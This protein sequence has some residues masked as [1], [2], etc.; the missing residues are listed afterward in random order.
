MVR[1][2]AAGAVRAAV[3]GSACLALRHQ[4]DKSAVRIPAKRG[5][6]VLWELAN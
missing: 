3:E 6:S 4:W 2:S 1:L 5:R